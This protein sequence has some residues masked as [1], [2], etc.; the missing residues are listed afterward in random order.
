L[1]RAVQAGDVTVEHK[2]DRLAREYRNDPTN[3]KRNR[4]QVASIVKQTEVKKKKLKTMD[5]LIAAYEQ[6]ANDLM[7][8][9]GDVEEV[10]DLYLG[11]AR[12]AAPEKAKAVAQGI[13]RKPAPAY[14]KEQ[15]QAIIDRLDMPGKKID[16][17][18][19]AIDGTD[20]QLSKQEG[21][22][23]LIYFWATWGQ[24]SMAALPEIKKA[25]SSEVILVGVNMDQDLETAKKA[26]AS[27][28]LPGIHHFDA[29]GLNGSVA[30]Q[31]HVW[32]M[33]GVYVFNAKGI[34]TGFGTT[35]DLA[36]LLAAARK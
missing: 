5:E 4:F 34:L 8:E 19:T 22:I 28:G 24:G 27:E 35:R 25:A 23:V 18:L 7:A 12:N 21:K 17:E 20:F 3:P 32:Q 13:L 1:L 14:I 15:A 10:Y 29:R 9:Y 6:N 33:P 36:N 30:T 16:L 26:I 2:A 31:L 11:V